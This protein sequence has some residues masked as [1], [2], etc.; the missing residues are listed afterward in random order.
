MDLNKLPG[1]YDDREEAE[2]LL[3]LAKFGKDA[4]GKNRSA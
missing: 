1:G 3:N 2:I 4:V